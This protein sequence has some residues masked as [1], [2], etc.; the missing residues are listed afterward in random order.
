MYLDGLTGSANARKAL[1]WLNKAVESN[2]TSAMYTLGKLYYE[3]KVV[4]QKRNTGLKLLRGA[5][6]QGS[7]E[8]GKYLSAL[9]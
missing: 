5:N 6:D 7:K 3:G 9:Q 4:M 2:H 8:A 1:E